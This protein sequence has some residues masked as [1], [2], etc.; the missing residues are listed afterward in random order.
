MTRIFGLELGR[1]SENGV[2][3]DVENDF[4]GICYLCGSAGLFLLLVFL[5]Y[6]LVRILL[7]LRKQF[8]ARFTPMFIG[9]LLSIVCGLAH[10]VFTAGVFRRPNANFYLAAAIALLWVLTESTPVSKEDA[11]L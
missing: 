1:L 10:A 7:S 3:Y 9:G 2:S 5:G 8:R 4:H 6:F 11:A